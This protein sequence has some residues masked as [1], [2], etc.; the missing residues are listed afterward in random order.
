M[1]YHKR[2]ANKYANYARAAAGVAKAVYNTYKSR[3]GYK[4]RKP[5]AKAR[6]SIPALIGP[7]R[8]LDTTLWDEGY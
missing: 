3:K 8:Y 6:R 7:R 1:K 4:G 2:S 5:A